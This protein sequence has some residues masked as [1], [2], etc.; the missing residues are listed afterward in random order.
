MSRK[1]HA[2]RNNKFDKE[3]VHNV[4]LY[5]DEDNI[6]HSLN[7]RNNWNL[8]NDPTIRQ[9]K[10]HK[11][12]T[13]DPKSMAVTNKSFNHGGGHYS[14]Y[15][16]GKDYVTVN[17]NKQNATFNLIQERNYILLPFGENEYPINREAHT[18]YNTPC[19]GCF[20]RHGR[21]WELKGL[22]DKS[23][24]K[25]KGMKREKQRDFKYYHDL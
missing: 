16:K 4:S 13:S 25:N 22:G 5:I 1:H 3:Y 8:L 18:L 11:D 24:H 17:D 19:K 20:Q 21:I 23:K 9:I 6:E 7:K 14:T 10:C 15:K 12:V 2:I